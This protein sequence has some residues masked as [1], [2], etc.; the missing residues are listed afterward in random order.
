MGINLRG[1]KPHDRLKGVGRITVEGGEALAEDAVNL[2]K[3]W[4][5]EDP[6]VISEH[7]DAGGPG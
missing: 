7:A 2:I 5:S 6:I 3:R 4:I 1:D